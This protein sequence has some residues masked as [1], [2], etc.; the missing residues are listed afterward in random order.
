MAA[1]AA[2]EVSERLGGPL[3]LA[4]SLPCLEREAPRGEAAASLK[5]PSAAEGELH[6]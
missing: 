2:G 3:P 4:P 1:G 6:F 5:T